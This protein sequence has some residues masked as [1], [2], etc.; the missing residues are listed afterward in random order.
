MMLPGYAALRGLMR[1]D[2]RC[3][4]PGIAAVSYVGTFALIAPVTIA[5]YIWQWPL[6]VV[7]LTLV[8]LIG[9]ALLTITVRGWWRE[10]GRALA[11]MLCLEAA[12]LA[13]DLVLGARVG[14][15]YGADAVVHLM[16]IRELREH[17]MSNFHPAY[18]FPSF[19]PIYHTNIFHAMVAAIAQLGRINLFDAWWSTLL[20]GKVVTV[21]A[22]YFLGW[23]VYEREW[24][25]WAGA[26]LVGTALAPLTFVLYPNKLAPFWLIPVALAQVIPL[27]TR[28]GRLRDVWLFAAAAFVLG[29]VHG[30]YAV[31]LGLAV[32]PVWLG[33]LLRRIWRGPRRYA[34]LLVALSA[35]LL[36]VPFVL[37]SYLV[38]RA[39]RAAPAF[40]PLERTTLEEEPHRFLTVGQNFVMV[41]PS[42]WR[43]VGIL[44]GLCLS[45]RSPRRD[46]ARVLFL[47][48]VSVG[49][50]LFVPL[51]C[52]PLLRAFGEAWMVLRM[53][54]F[55]ALGFA[56]LAAGGYAH[57]L[58]RRLQA[59]PEAAAGPTRPR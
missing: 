23:R 18:A 12:L 37:T 32:A 4:A 29:Q 41:R 7:T 45:L 24:A 36:P 15:I 20:W 6:A 56:V 54:P 51:L 19:L 33:F 42:G 2:L 48:S 13:V 43:E 59:A 57:W 52:T 34:P 5:S 27:C 38:E 53:Y 3:G 8:G 1:D 46:E 17:G 25:A 58:E 44:L 40:R 11:S 16:Q 30:M 14:P 47:I 10:L 31:F 49:A 28:S 22:V 21:G 26:V 39:P 55:I 9:L 50:W 35:L